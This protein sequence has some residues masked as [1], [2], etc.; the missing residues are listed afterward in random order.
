MKIVV[1]Q[2]LYRQWIP[3][4]ASLYLQPAWM[5]IF[6]DWWEAR[7]AID[8]EGQ[9]VWMW[10]YQ[11]RN[12]FLFKKYGRL[13]YCPDN[14]PIFLQ[15]YVGREFDPGIRRWLSMCVV[16]DRA[17][18]LDRTKMIT[19]GWTTEKRTYQYFDLPQYP[20]GL[21]S[22]SRSK[23][24]RMM[25]SGGLVCYLLDNLSEAS[26]L[27]LSYFKAHGQPGIQY[28]GLKRIKDLVDQSFDTYLFGI[29]NTHGD[30][31]AIQWL[32][33]YRDTLYGWIV[34]RAPQAPVNNARE[35]L[36]WHI[37]QWAR[38]RYLKYDLGGSSLPGVRSFNLEMGAKETEY[39]RFV[40]FHPA[41]IGGFG[42]K[43]AGNSLKTKTF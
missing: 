7:V 36:L 23:R 20:M 17:N 11:E 2:N 22:I 31:L 15:D 12:R 29:Q 33:G 26:D 35:L 39:T 16:D 1:D 5:D 13:A 10:P 3:P 43:F 4:E 8:G 38:D 41:W 21:E 19:Q 34:V 25:K 37:I 40:R 6:N 42:R 28:A 30:L 14:G 32:V 24:K 27:L 9:P 18:Q